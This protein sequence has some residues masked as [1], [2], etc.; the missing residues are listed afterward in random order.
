MVTNDSFRQFAVDC[1]HWAERASDPSHRQTMLNVAN[2]WMNVALAIDRAIGDGA[3]FVL[4]DL[5][6]KLD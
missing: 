4:P 6:A 1:G 3:G 2:M 5:R